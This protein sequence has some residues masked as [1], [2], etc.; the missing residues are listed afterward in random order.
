MTQTFSYNFVYNLCF[1]FLY[2]L[3]QRSSVSKILKW[4]LPFIDRCP[5]RGYFLSVII[6]LFGHK[7]RIFSVTQGTL[8]QGKTAVVSC[9]V[10]QF[11]Y[12]VLGWLVKAN[13]IYKYTKQKIQ[14]QQQ[15]KRFFITVHWERSQESWNSEPNVVLLLYLHKKNKKEENKRPRK[16][17]RKKKGGEKE[18]E[19]RQYATK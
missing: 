4:L 10:L 13:Y 3:C 6:H 5:W 9:C 16:K 19:K 15:Q 18:R 12:C 1:T 17:E 8:D 2:I 14:Q 11:E 7:G